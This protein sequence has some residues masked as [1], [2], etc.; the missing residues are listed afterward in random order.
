ME[1]VDINFILYECVYRNTIFTCTLVNGT[2]IKISISID[3]TA[4]VHLV[5][6]LSFRIAV[7]HA[8]CIIIVI[9]HSL[10]GTDNSK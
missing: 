9:A 5:F 6:A 8:V 4:I 10:V 7:K 2:I 1:Y 3:P